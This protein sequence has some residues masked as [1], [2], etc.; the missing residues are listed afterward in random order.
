MRAVRR[1]TWILSAAAVF[2]LTAPV[3]GQSTIE[4]EFPLPAGGAV[5]VTVQGGSV[6]VTGGSRTQARVVAS[7]TSGELEAAYDLRFEQGADGLMIFAKRKGG[8][9]LLE[10]LGLG[11]RGALK[12]AIEVPEATRVT[13]DAGGGAVELS[14]TRGAARLES[15]GGPIRA[16]GVAGPVSAESSGGSVTL[17]RIDGDVKA[18]TAGGSIHL[19]D[20]RGSAEAETSGGPIEASAVGGLLRAEASGGPIRVEEAAG[21][22]EAETSGGSIDVAFARG[23]GHGGALVAVGG[24]IDVKLDPAVDLVVEAEAAGGTVTSDLTWSGKARETR[25][26]LR[27]TLGAGGAARLR[28]ETAGG[29]IRIRGR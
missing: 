22:V 3:F 26:E 23:N 17:E 19:R 29:S 18:E 14:G 2:L 24:G 7:L 21:R 12:M 8:G 16:I 28:L 15:A 6:E 20:I 9:S 25:T 10:W 5:F 1:T 11:D 13:V 27:G 4:R